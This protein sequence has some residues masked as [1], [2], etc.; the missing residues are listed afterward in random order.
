MSSPKND[1]KRKRAVANP[2]EETNKKSDEQFIKENLQ[3]RYD[4]TTLGHRRSHPASIFGSYGRY[5]RKNWQVGEQI[6]VLT[7]H[8]F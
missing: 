3:P 2:I 8:Q 6:Y 1:A 7:S 5:T 4:M